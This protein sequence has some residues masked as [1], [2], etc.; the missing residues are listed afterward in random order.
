MPSLSEYET[1]HLKNLSLYGKR[2]L[3][4][5]HKYVDL[6][7]QR[8]QGITV[9][10]GE[11]FDINKYPVLKRLLDEY[12]V[13]M[14]A[15]LKTSIVN[16]VQ[17]EWKLSNQKNDDWISLAIKGRDLPGQV[18]ERF[19]DKNLG[20]LTEFIE[21]KEAGLNLSDRVWKA[22]DQFRTEIEGGLQLGITDGKPAAQMANDMKGFLQDP[23]R[24]F[25]R[26][27]D[28][29][30]NLKLSKAAKAYHPGAGRYRSSF[31]NARR[32]AATE[33]NMAYR[34]ADNERWKKMGFVTGY[35]VKLS[36][37]HPVIDICD[38]LKGKYPKEFLFRGWHPLCRCYMI[39][40]K[41]DEETFGNY[42]DSIMD[43]TDQNFDFGN[44]IETPPAGLTTWLTD[45]AERIK[46]WKNV[47]YFMKDNPTFF[48]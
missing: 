28:E 45:N 44:V 37:N 42:L 20:A 43:G 2:I 1:Q 46:G 23:D 18:M 38:D 10:E 35:E 11:T 21:R 25:R 33:T 26:V 4:I 30:G 41:P 16:G 40:I 9:P 13:K 39:P 22:Q 47:P 8:V 5:Y 15:E 34:K 31:R 12:G 6:I 24:L 29:Q 36:G 27:R 17:N 48:K 3:S 19:F 7:F 32:L 14:Q